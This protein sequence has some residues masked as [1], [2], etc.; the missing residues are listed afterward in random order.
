LSEL[1]EIIVERDSDSRINLLTLSACNTAAGSSRS[2]LGMAGVAVRSG[3]ENVLGS[4]WSVSDQEMAAFTSN[5]YHYWIEKKLTKS[6]ALRQ[7]QID[8]IRKSYVHPSVWT[9]L[10][11]IYA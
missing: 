8:F 9:S 2:V 6:E 7:A 3:V 10:I 4:L 1:E 5:F 11:L